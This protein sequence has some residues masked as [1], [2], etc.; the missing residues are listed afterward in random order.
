MFLK[1]TK[2]LESDVSFILFNLLIGRIVHRRGSLTAG[3]AP[4]IGGW[5][6]RCL[7]LQVS[8]VSINSCDSMGRPRYTNSMVVEYHYHYRADSVS[9][10]WSYCMNRS[11][12]IYNTVEPG[13]VKGKLSHKGNSMPSQSMNTPSI[14]GGVTVPWPSSCG[15]QG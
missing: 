15:V 7:S 13:S 12:N 9:S 11:Y 10:L 3:R 5:C 4:L 2:Y 8:R 6:T 1:Y 14:V